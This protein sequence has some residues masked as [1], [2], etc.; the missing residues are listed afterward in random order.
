MEWL[1]LTVEFLRSF[2]PKFIFLVGAISAVIEFLIR[3]TGKEKVRNFFIGAWMKLNHVATVSFKDLLISP[4]GRKILLVCSTLMLVIPN[5]GLMLANEDVAGDP[6]SWVFFG[7]IVAIGGVVFYFLRNRI[8][9]YID[10]SLNSEHALWTLLRLSAGPAI[11]I[12]AMAAAG[13]A[14]PPLNTLA[15]ILFIPFS[16]TVSYISAIWLVYLL[17]LLLYGI[18]RLLFL[19][20]EQLCLRIAEAERGPVLAVAVA[21]AIVGFVLDFTLP[22][23]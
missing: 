8:N 12:A 1:A 10:A 18:A 9:R 17:F 23:P 11:G 4:T 3:D 6:A 2:G 13:L 5:V 20:F 14:P 19:A 21:C 7:F 15:S 16:F 22:R